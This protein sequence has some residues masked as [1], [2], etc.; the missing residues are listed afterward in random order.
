MQVVRP[1]RSRQ[2]RRRGFTLIELLVVISIIA[3]LAALLLP[4]IQQ[5]RE[6]ARRTQCLNNMRNIG[7][8]VQAFSASQN[9]KVPRLQRRSLPSAPSPKTLVG[10]GT[11]TVVGIPWTVELLPYI[12]QRA[13]YDRLL[14]TTVGA[15]D[16][17]SA[18]PL[19]RVKIDVFNCPNDPN[20][21]SDGNLSFVGNGGYRVLSGGSFL[22]NNYVEAYDWPFNATGAGNF[23]TNDF[24]ATAATGV[25]FHEQFDGGIQVTLDGISNGDGTSQTLLLAE[26]LQATEWLPNPGTVALSSDTIS[27]VAISNFNPSTLAFYF[28]ILGSS[29]TL[30]TA[31]TTTNGCGTTGTAMAPTK[32][33]GMLFGTVLDHTAANFS[34]Y[35]IND[36]L[37]ATEGGRAR[38]SSLHPGVV[39]VVFCD[40]RAKN[41]NSSMD[42]K[43]Y[44]EI[45]S[46]N[47]KAFGQRILSDTDF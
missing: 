22:T 14:T 35:R 34:D 28:P 6:T 17:T 42:V 46:S 29:T 39:N 40:G 24:Q 16:T 8:A 12:E 19:G 10:T 20:R 25:F 36:G 47:G 26:N 2:P 21:N 43:L 44:G 23:D 3:T 9:G 27:M 18:N 1:L 5:A 41:L 15:H 32:V 31:N 30:V 33:T 37:T 45:V 4:A 7:I 13:L 11:G 38:P